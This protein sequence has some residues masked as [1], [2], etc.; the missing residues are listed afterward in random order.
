VPLHA[1]AELEDVRRLV[2]LRWEGAVKNYAPNMGYDYGG[3]LQAAW[4]DR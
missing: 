4:L 2:R 1:L 3:R